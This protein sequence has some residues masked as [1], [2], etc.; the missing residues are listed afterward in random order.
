MQ[1]ICLGCTT[2]ILKQIIINFIS[3]GEILIIP[4]LRIHK[5]NPVTNEHACIIITSWEEDADYINNGI[6]S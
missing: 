2:V 5:N 4:E 1:R 3:W 6:R